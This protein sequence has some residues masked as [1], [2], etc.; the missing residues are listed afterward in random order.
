MKKYPMVRQRGLKDCGPACILMILKYY[1][2]YVSLDKLCDML[3]TNNKGTTAYHMI[4]VLKSLGFDS[5]GYKYDDLSSIKCPCIALI[6]IH[7]YNHYVVIYK[8]NFKKKNLIIGDP[9][10]GIVK[11]KFK[12]FL[13]CFD[14]IIISMTL[15]HKLVKEGE[16]NVFDFIFNLIK[17]N[18]KYLFLISFFSLIISLLSIFSSFFI[19][20][21][22]TYLNSSLIFK[23][24]LFFSFLFLILTFTG[25][26]RNLILIKLNQNID[27]SLSINTFKHII[28]LPYK[29]AKNKTTGEI[30]SYFNDLFLIKDVINHVAVSIFIDIPL[31]IIL[32]ILLYF[33]H[34]RLF[35]INM[36]IFSLYLV[37]YIS[38]KKKNYCLM[39]KVLREK[40]LI[41]SFITESV[42]GYETIR[43]LNLQE[44]RIND[45]SNKYIN[46]LKISK[47]LENTKNME[48]LFKEIISNLSLILIIIYGVFNMR[49][50]LPVEMF[51]TI[52]LLSTILNSSWA[53]ILNFDFEY[54]GVKSSINHI[55]E[56]FI[57]DYVKDN[58]SVNGDIFVNN[59]NYSFNK[60]DFILKN[61]NLSIKLGSK[62]MVSGK[63]GS[64]KST[65]FKII[66]G[67]YDDYSGKALIDKFHSNKSNFENVLYISPKEILFTGKIFDNLNIRKMDIEN[68]NICELPE[69]IGDYNDV[70]EEEGF[71]ISDG[72]RQRIALARALSNF[73]ILIIDEGLSQVDVNMERRILK[74]L[75]KKYEDKTI[76]FISHRLD[77]LDLFDRFLKLEGGR[78]VL[79]EVRN[80]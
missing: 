58:V 32:L 77:N 21:V 49:N 18:I 37:L 10:K 44:K 68:N 45:F 9:S 25:Y 15:K 61:I 46:Y 47:K 71:N 56:L 40:S 7:S 16:I 35:V 67:Y 26:I 20:S 12:E 65:L 60:V 76:I 54:E 11:V 74:K 51:I 5:D 48:F 30:I 33:I 34:F 23:I 43:N 78:V 2:G 72:Q 62:V 31:I 80:I 53:N 8:I 63:S 27:I 28:R 59:L 24:I 55:G 36:F 73:Q 4:Q 14:G 69:F 22:I 39:E 75:F 64:G 29:H 42:K 3:C 17:P 70:V 41:N 50:G 52:F 13:S 19:Q 6:N 79:D 57:N 1:G 66:K 38:F